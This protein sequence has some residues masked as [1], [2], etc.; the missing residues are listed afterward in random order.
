MAEAV[1]IVRS[2]TELALHLSESQQTVFFLHTRAR[3]FPRTT[4]SL[5]TVGVRLL[6]HPDLWRCS[7]HVPAD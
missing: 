7:E 6:L 1:R 3:A 4:P 5:F 2:Q